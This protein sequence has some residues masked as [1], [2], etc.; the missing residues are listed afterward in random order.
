[1]VISSSPRALGFNAEAIPLDI[2]FGHAVSFGITD[3]IAEYR[4]LP[5]LFGIFYR[6]GEQ[7]TE[8]VPME[9]VVAQHQ[10]GAIIPDEFFSNDE[11][12]GQA[13]RRGL[14]RIR[15]MYAEIA[16]VSEQATECRQVLGRRYDQD[17]PD[18]RHH[19]GRYGIIDHRLVENG[20]ELLAH[21]FRNRVK[22]GTRT[23]SQDNSFHIYLIFN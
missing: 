12:L 5:L 8:T 11:G 10:A 21:A 3:P 16:S 17:V 18:A 1:M 23:S 22:P 6:P 15:E 13:V 19:K 2:E 20:Q 7:F 4:R 14:L 9:D